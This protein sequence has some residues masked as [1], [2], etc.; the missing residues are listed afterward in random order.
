MPHLLHCIAAYLQVGQN[1]ICP[2]GV[3]T[4]CGA[5]AAGAVPQLRFTDFLANRRIVRCPAILR[6][7]NSEGFSL[8]AA[9]ECVVQTLSA[10]AL[11][12]L[13]YLVMQ[14]QQMLDA[15]PADFKDSCQARSPKLH[16][17]TSPRC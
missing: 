4:L 7:A 3:R 8:E 17:L 13:E 15:F 9:V 16:L 5:F 10:G 12:R 11:P 14:G 1:E 6:P 2:P